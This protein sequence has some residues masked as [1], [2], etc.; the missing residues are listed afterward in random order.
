MSKPN[1]DDITY[2]SLAK[3][4]DPTGALEY[5]PETIFRMDAH[6][7]RR[8]PNSNLDQAQQEARRRMAL[9]PKL[10][11]EVLFVLPHLWV[12]VVQLHQRLFILPGVPSLFTQLV[13]ALVA[14]YI[15][16]PPSAE[17]PRECFCFFYLLYRHCLWYHYSLEL[18]MR[19]CFCCFVRRSA[20]HRY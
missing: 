20:I 12:P 4:W 8:R 5:D 19:I 15:H 13:D 9:F 6:T 1:A 10:N 16:L 14:N 2:Q 3:V 7:A 11:R 17:Q 18:L